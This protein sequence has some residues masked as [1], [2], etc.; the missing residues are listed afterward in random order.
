ML[1]S[2]RFLGMFYYLDLVQC[3]VAVFFAVKTTFRYTAADA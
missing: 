2:I 3:A 1:D